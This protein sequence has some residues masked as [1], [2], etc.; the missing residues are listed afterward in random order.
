MWPTTRRR[1]LKYSTPVQREGSRPVFPPAARWNAQA[2]LT[3]AIVA[4]LG[5]L[6]AVAGCWLLRVEDSAPDAPPPTAE[7]IANIQKDFGHFDEA[8]TPESK[9]PLK[10]AGL[11]RGRPPLQP[12]LA[13]LP[14]LPLLPIGLQRNCFSP[15][16][17]H[18]N[19]P[20][21]TFCERDLLTRFCINRR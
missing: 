19:A 4:T 17:Y 10:S 14:Q 12:R 20:S 18:A 8:T 9:A 1:L 13:S 6:A 16:T 11:R 7:S 5:L 3:I 2:R 21:A 15:L